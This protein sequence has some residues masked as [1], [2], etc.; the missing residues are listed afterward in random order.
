MK[1]KQKYMYYV[2]KNKIVVPSNLARKIIKINKKKVYI[3]FNDLKRNRIIS[4]KTKQK[5]TKYGQL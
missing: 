2:N 4:K 5:E 1:I 3:N